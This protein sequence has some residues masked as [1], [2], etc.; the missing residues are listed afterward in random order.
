MMIHQSFVESN[1]VI[2]SSE[3]SLYF[4]E[5]HSRLPY[6]SQVEMTCF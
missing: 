4:E 1:S 5:L 6:F 3:G 2:P